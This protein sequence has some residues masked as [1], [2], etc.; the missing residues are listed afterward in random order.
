MNLL[1]KNGRV[2]DPAN[3]INKETD[4][5]VEDGKIVSIGR[6]NGKKTGYEKIDAA[7]KIVIP[8]LIDMH[9]HLRDPGYE[10]KE[11]IYSG[12]AAANAGGFTSIA[13]MPNTSPVNDKG[14]VT[15]YI[16]NR[17]KTYGK[18]SIFPVGA[19]TKGQKGK[20]LA[21]IGEL[22]EAGAAAV[23]DDGNPIENSELMRRVLEYSGMF[24]LPVISHCEDLSLSKNGVM[25]EG[26]VS[27]E[28]GLS[29]IPNASEETMVARDISLLRLTKGRLHIAHVSA[30]ESIKFI[31]M[32]KREGLQVTCEATP[33]HFTLTDEAVKGFDTNT[34]VNPPLR[35]KKD[36]EA[37]KNGLKDGTIDA[38]AT[39][40]APHELSEK[41]VEYDYAPFGISGL[42]TALPLALA[43]YF[44]NVLSLEEVISKLTINPAGILGIKKGTL[45]IGADADITIVDL[46]KDT[47][48]DVSSFR[49]KG[50]NSPFNGW[51]LKGAVETTIFKGKVVYRTE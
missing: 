45:S 4:V 43:L 22:K 25:N 41:M 51:K 30:A 23:S 28:L 40:H 36:I 14:A 15:E 2:V 37:I 29:G 8:G 35:T 6:S 11:D 20:N 3:N 49:S 27:T 18:V 12:G 38:I 21:E 33:H 46:N 42:E 47:A 9:T 10:Y 39:D 44:N 16:L 24:H 26:F 48:I 32:A 7:N 17:A 50:K 19:A 31:R 5:F 13:A 34:K 1:I